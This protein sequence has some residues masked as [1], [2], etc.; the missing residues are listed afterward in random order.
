MLDRK[1]I[2]S[3]ENVSKCVCNLWANQVSLV[4][5]LIG[6]RLL[7]VKK[8]HFRVPRTLTFKMRPSAPFSSNELYL[9]ENEKSFSYQ[10]PST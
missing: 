4:T 1:K 7:N 2:M 5:E 3:D 10:S 8:G 9:Y 6:E